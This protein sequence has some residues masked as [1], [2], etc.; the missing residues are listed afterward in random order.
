VMTFTHAHEPRP[1]LAKPLALGNISANTA[2]P[3]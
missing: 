3:P 1:D 2:H